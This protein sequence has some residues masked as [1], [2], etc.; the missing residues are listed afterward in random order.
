MLLNGVSNGSVSSLFLCYQLEI[1]N[2][3]ANV[4]FI[5]KPAE[6]SLKKNSDSIS[7]DSQ[8]SEKESGLI[9]LTSSWTMAD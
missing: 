2:F 1:K 6:K 4:S 8:C 9:L 5:Q 7:T 3:F